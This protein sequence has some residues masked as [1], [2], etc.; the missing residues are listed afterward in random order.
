[1]CFCHDAK[2]G[3]PLGDLVEGRCLFLGAGHACVKVDLGEPRL[4]I[5]FDQGL[6]L[7]NGVFSGQVLPGI[8]ANVIAAKDQPAVRH[9]GLF[10]QTPD[11][12]CKVSRSHA[13]IAAELIDLIAG[14]LNQNRYV[15]PCRKGG[16]LGQ[17]MGI[18]RAKTGQSLGVPGAVLGNYVL[19]FHA[20]PS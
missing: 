10:R 3:R 15:V 1:M 20:Q 7:Q 14:R 16:D 5:I 18:G 6:D 12:F 4:D 19:D 2:R 9:A 17:N 13:G 11:Q 8:W